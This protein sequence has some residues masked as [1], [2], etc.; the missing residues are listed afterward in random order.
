LEYLKKSTIPQ[1]TSDEKLVIMAMSGNTLAFTSLVERHTRYV[2]GIAS[3]FLIGEDE[4]RDVVQDTFIRVWK[5]LAN[6]DG[7]SLFTTWLYAIVF[8]LC[9]DRIRVKKRKTEISLTEEHMGRIN[10]QADAVDPVNDID[11]GSITRAIRNFSEEL[12]KVQRHVFVLRDLHD[13]PVSEVCRLTGY[14]TDKVKAN[15]Y[16]ARKFMR[17]K[18]TRG[19]YL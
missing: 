5:H 8:N 15:L 13:L 17:E 16:H 3:R 10:E 12:S 2:S 18:L 9:L 7:R 6:Y 1:G 11:S 14:D 19:G 4:T